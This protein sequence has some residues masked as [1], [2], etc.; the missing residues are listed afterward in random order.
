MFYCLLL[1]PPVLW[2]IL[3][4][5]GAAKTLDY[6]TGEKRNKH[7]VSEDVSLGN[8][9]SELE[10]YYN[11]RVPFRSV[12]LS[13]NGRLNSVLEWPYTK[14]IQPGL[15]AWANASMKKEQTVPEQMTAS[16]QEEEQKTKETPKATKT[17]S[18]E[19]AQE[20][21]KTQETQEAQETP[22]ELP[23]SDTEQTE[24]YPYIELSDSVI[25]GR[26]GWLFSQDEIVDYQGTDIP[27]EEELA[28]VTASMQTLRQI[29]ENKGIELYYLTI[30]NKSTVYSEYMPSIDKADYH[31]LNVLED[32]VH[33]NT[34]LRFEF[35]DR[36]MIDSKVYGKLYFFN[37]S[38]WNGRGALAGIAALHRMMGLDEID[39]GSMTYEDG[40]YFNGD[41]IDLTGMP[42]DNFVQETTVDYYYKKDVAVQMIRGGSD[43]ID[44]FIS[45]APDGRTVVLV[46]DSYRHNMM[47]YL[48]SDFAHIYFINNYVLSADCLDILESADV[49]IVENI[50][51]VFFYQS[52]ALDALSALIA[53][54]G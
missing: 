40:D 42:A 30:P 19:T 2:G 38:H 8:L 34:D 15:I 46:G 27:S 43:D 5:F 21:Q 16:A 11:D 7:A 14:G 6:D 51:R 36:E 35:I 32:Y 29:C 22:A 33:N 13:V 49:I 47:P 37:D 25:Q 31:A 3:S 20:T 10:L 41:L 53:I 48:P 24:F 50:E 45:D 23:A 54:M 52:R 1:I 26:D 9:T 39:M 4:I 28:A 18:A 17:E 12:M 44:E